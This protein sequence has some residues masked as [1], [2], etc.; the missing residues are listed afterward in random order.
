MIYIDIGNKS[1]L[2]LPTSY[3][4]ILKKGGYSNLNSSTVNQVLGTSMKQICLSLSNVAA[5]L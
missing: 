3:E 5:S 4:K 1:A 2:D